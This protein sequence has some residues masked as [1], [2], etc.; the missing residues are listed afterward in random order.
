MISSSSLSDNCDQRCHRDFTLRQLVC[1]ID[2]TITFSLEK[3]QQ[4]VDDTIL[5]DDSNKCEK[6]L[7]QTRN[8]IIFLVVSDQYGESFVPRLHHMAHI[9]SIHI[10]HRSANE[11]QQE[12]RN[13]SK[14]SETP[15]N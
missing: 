5:F 15:F 6:F 14:V 12:Q 10:C 1:L 9:W 2:N 11:K 4:L 8:T 3:L 7:E 13:V